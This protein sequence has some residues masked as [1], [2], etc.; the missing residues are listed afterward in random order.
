ML[1]QR[2]NPRSWSV[3][4]RPSSRAIQVAVWAVILIPGVCVGIAA[5]AVAEVLTINWPTGGKS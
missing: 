4:N 3:Q 1:C 5:A 2:L